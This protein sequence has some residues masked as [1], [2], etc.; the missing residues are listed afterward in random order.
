[1]K[2]EGVAGEQEEA[3]TGWVDLPV[4]PWHDLLS[5][6]GH[7]GGPTPAAHLLATL[8]HALLIRA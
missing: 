1:M 2:V 8:P 4:G 5:D 6:T 7:L 3:V